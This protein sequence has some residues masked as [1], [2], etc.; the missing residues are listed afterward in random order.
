M[1]A[2]GSLYFGGIVSQS[3]QESTS[4]VPLLVKPAYL[5][6]QH[7]LEGQGTKSGGQFLTGHTE[8]DILDEIE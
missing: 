7:G 8:T 4:G 6:P 3:C 2:S 1:C 5:L